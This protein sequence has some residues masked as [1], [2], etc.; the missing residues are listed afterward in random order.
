VLKRKLIPAIK[1]NW[2][3]A[4]TGKVAV[5]PGYAAEVW[6][7]NDQWENA[8]SNMNDAWLNGNSGKAVAE[9]LK[10]ATSLLDETW[11]RLYSKKSAR[12]RS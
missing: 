6:L 11:H 9:F 7:S 10:A 1:Q 4:T 2:I 5:V 3:N 12:S 8:L